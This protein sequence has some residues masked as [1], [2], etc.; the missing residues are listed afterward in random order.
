MH[1]EDNPVRSFIHSRGNESAGTVFLHCILFLL[2]DN[3]EQYMYHFD[4]YLCACQRI[5]SI[6]K[7]F[8]FLSRVESLEVEGILSNLMMS[9]LRL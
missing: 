3:R 7:L 8:K 9:S 5:N 6:P 1:R 2:H 4:Y